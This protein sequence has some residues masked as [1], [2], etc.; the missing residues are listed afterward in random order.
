VG[1]KLLD[2]RPDPLQNPGKP[3]LLPAHRPGDE[4]IPFFR[5]NIK[6]ETVDPQEGVRRGECDALVAV[7]EAVIVIQRLHQRRCLFFKRAVIPG[8]RTENGG[9]DCALAPDALDDRT[10]E[11]L[12]LVIL[13]TQ[14]FAQ[15]FL[16]NLWKRSEQ[17]YVIGT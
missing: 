16:I 11:R 3:K 9:L 17:V 14:L 4:L 10:N 5:D 8:L 7:Y 13:M 2:V 6:I 1:L 12:F 15:V